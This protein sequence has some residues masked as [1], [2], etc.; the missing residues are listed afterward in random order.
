MFKLVDIDDNLVDPKVIIAEWEGKPRCLPA[1]L[2]Y[3][4]IGWFIFPVPIGTK[5]SHK[6]AKYSGDR[7]WGM[8]RDADEIRQNWR[9][10]P[11]ANIG[12]PTGQVNGIFVVEADTVEGHGVDGIAA[13]KELEARHGKLPDTLMA[14]SPSGSIHYY[15][16]HP[17]GYIKNSAS[18]L[19]PGVDTKADGGMVVAPPSVK[20]GVGTYRWLNQAEIADAPDWLL[21]L[22]TDDAAAE[23]RDRDVERQQGDDPE[24]DHDLIAA[25]LAV[26]PNADIGWEDWNSVGMAAWSATGGSD[27]GFKAFDLW[28]QKAKKYNKNNTTEKWNTYFTCPPTSIGAGTI[29]W[30]ADAADRMWRYGSDADDNDPEPDHADDT[31]GSM[32]PPRSR[33]KSRGEKTTVLV[34]A[35]DVVPRRLDWLWKGHLVRG[36]QELMTGVPG[37][38]KSQVQCSLVACIT[39]GCTWPNGDPGIGEPA[40]VI[41]LT[42]ED[43][44]DQTVV[45][46]LMAAGADLSR[47]YFLTYIKTDEKK[48]Q[49][50][51]EEDLETLEKEIARIGN[52]ALVTVDPITAYMGGRIDSHNTTQVRSQLGPLKDL[53]ERTNVCFSTITHP[54]KNAGKRAIDHFIGSQAFIAACRIGHACFEEIGE[55]DRPT[56]RILFT[57]VKNNLSVKMPTLAYRIV[58]TII[59]QDSATGDA[60]HAPHVVWAEEAVDITADAAV[61]A[62]IGGGSRDASQR[63]VRQFLQTILADGAKPQRE[64]IDEAGQHGFSLKQVKA[65]K[66]KLEIISFKE[67]GVL[68]GGWIWKLPDVF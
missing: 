50:I 8:T 60:I 1:A 56:G 66:K 39:T 48:R 12:V 11:D 36:A 20:P 64:I 58:D 46:R 30:L 9:Q 17:G 35:N 57:N 23:R 33:K 5:Q 16:R 14:A 45:P 4:G 42:A 27:V 41:M 2:A 19:A 62:S 13:L 10:W 68:V 52:V 49:F 15:F 6:S 40:N 7:K 18:K 32:P 22:V 55:D 34:R 61:A 54:A 44:I 63:E 53:S 59:D 47:V 65:A 29:F 21:K 28:S 38:G 37:Y 31:R 3:A 51:L 67:P 26:I 25:A 24:A 43:V